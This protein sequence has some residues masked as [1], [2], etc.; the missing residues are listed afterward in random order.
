[1]SSKEMP[2][3]KIGN[4]TARVPVVQGGMGIGIS[5]SGLAS[6]VANAGG[7]GV[8]SAVGVGM[9]E[10]DFVKD[11]SSANKR[12]LKKEL[13]KARAAS[14]GIIGVNIM[15]A[16][17][18]FDE[19]AKVAIEEGADLLFLGAGLPLKVPKNMSE[20]M[21][22][23]FLSKVVP[24]VSSAEVANLIFSYWVKK[25]NRVP[26][27]VVVE[28]PL[29]GGHLGFKLEQLDDPEFAL[30]KIVPKVVETIK[31]FEE[32]FHKKIPVIAGGGVYSGA[33]IHHLF[34]LGA[35]GAQLATRFVATNECDA[36]QEFKDAYLKCT[37][38]DIEII[39]SPVGM[40]GRAVSNKFLREVKA[41]EKKPYK[42]PWRCLTACNVKDSPYCIAEALTNA[43]AGDIDNGFCFAG[44]NVWR[45][46]KIVS[47]Q[48]LMD[49]L[50]DG[51]MACEK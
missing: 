50:T 16:L 39:K 17:T 31:K 34:S 35:S 18:D 38:D 33:D 41:G 49:E 45:V 20:E 22:D 36:S 28:G 24:I 25:Y 46:D 29:A 21:Q 8:I 47:V 15:L 42:C 10:P 9:G 37:K 48:E 44:A 14:K 7:I 4:L 30:E 3:L 2:A 12:G 19:L 13:Q 27:A 1:M 23:L 26:D 40:P 32:Q 6:A 51:F 11:V 43:K 5:L